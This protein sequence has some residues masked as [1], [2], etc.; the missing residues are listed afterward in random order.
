MRLLLPA[1]LSAPL[2][3]LGACA[4][5]TA[6]GYA[7]P[8]EGDSG[9]YA[10]SNTRADELYLSRSAPPSALGYR[11]V[12]IADANVD[13][14][15]VIQPEGVETDEAWVVTDEE[16]AVLQEDIEREFIDALGYQ[17]AF[18]IVESP[19]E[20][21]LIVYTTVVALHPNATREQVAAGEPPGGAVTISLALVDAESGAVLVRSVDTK[22]TEDIWSFQQIDNEEPAIDLIFR[23]WGNSMRRGI[24]ALQRRSND[25]LVTPLQL[26]EQ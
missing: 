22:S 5:N 12:Y 7:A 10:A 2:I 6:D 16:A 4:Q 1:A 9:F 21:E 25:P 18:N 3:L 11:D 19:E 26:E 15:V 20:A 13:S 24:L 23:S 17:S 8:E 14:M